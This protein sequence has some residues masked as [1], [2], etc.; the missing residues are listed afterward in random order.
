MTSTRAKVLVAA[1]VLLGVALMTKPVA[2]SVECFDY[3]ENCH[4]C[5]FDGGAGG[6]IRWCTRPAF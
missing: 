3:G 2:A 4:Y 1:L 5:V 6:Y